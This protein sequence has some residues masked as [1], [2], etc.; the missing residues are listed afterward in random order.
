MSTC[1]EIIT[2]VTPDCDLTFKFAATYSGGSVDNGVVTPATAAYHLNLCCKVIKLTVACSEGTKRIILGIPLTYVNG[3]NV[4]SL[5]L[6]N[7]TNAT[8][9]DYLYDANIVIEDVLYP[10]THLPIGLQVAN[11]Y[12]FVEIDV[13][14]HLILD[15]SPVEGECNASINLSFSVFDFPLKKKL[16]CCHLKCKP[17]TWT[18]GDDENAIVLSGAD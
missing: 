13:E 1:P 16:N 8:L 12:L 10:G 2:K 17:V 15:E 9:S 3:C 5:V 18:Y 6:P 7:I 11:G 14:N 4:Y